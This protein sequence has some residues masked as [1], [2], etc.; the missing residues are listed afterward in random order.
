[1]TKILSAEI[2]VLLSNDTAIVLYVL[3]IKADFAPHVP[4][5]KL[6]N[7]SIELIALAKR[8]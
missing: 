5:K 8:I 4:K 1:M 7:L 6:T 3:N 2:T